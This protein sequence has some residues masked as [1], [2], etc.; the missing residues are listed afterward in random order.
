MNKE[1][2]EALRR[3]FSKLRK[4][5]EPSTVAANLFSKGILTE[6]QYHDRISSLPN[7]AAK[8][9]FILKCVERHGKRGIFDVFVQSIE[10]ADPAIQYLAEELKEGRHR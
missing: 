5:L 7:D 9:E 8:N 4:S 1:E 10:N 2:K 6:E 3:Q